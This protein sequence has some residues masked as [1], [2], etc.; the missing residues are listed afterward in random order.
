[1]KRKFCKN[2]SQLLV[3]GVTAKIRYKCKYHCLDNLYIFYNVSCYH[4]FYI[5][6]HMTYSTNSW[7][8]NVS[9]V[10]SGDEC[11]VK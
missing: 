8:T 1:M 2:C 10:D 4:I 3:A 9:Y 7:T 6:Y 5:T 11:K